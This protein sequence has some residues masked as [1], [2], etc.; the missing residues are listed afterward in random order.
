MTPRS[1][2]DGAAVRHRG[3]PR[4]EISGGTFFGP[5]ALGE[6][7]T[8][9]LPRDIPPAMSG[10][11]PRSG[12]FAGRADLLER[13]AAA[14]AP[15]PEQAGAPVAAVAGLPG[16]GK[17]EA[18]LQAAD[19][20]CREEG[21]FP[22]GVLFVDLHG[23]RHDEAGGPMPPQR[24]LRSFLAML[25]VSAEHLPDDAQDLARLYRS[26]LT[27]YAD[28]DRRVLVVIDNAASTEQVL[29]LLPGD[30]RVPAL[31]TSRHTLADLTNVTLHDLGPLTPDASLD[32]LR[33]E[34][35]RKRGPEYARV[36]EEA[37]EA[38]RVAAL[39]GHLP[40]ALHIVA[41][42]LA[43]T[44]G[45]PLS[46]LADELA[47]AT[48]TLDGLE[49]GD[50]CVRAAFGL[51][52]AALPADQARLFR[53]LPLSVYDSISAPA[54]ARLLD[55]TEAG[56]R[57]LL[58]ALARANLLDTDPGGDRW[59]MHDLVGEYADERRLEEP[60]GED[61]G[62]ALVLLANHYHQTT[63]AAASHLQP[64]AAP[65]PRFDHRASA[66]AW[67]DEERDNLVTTV[68]LFEYLGAAGPCVT[69]A[70]KLSRYLEMRHHRED[71]LRVATAAVDAA[72]A[73]GDLLLQAWASDILGTALHTANLPEAATDALR[74][75]ARL[76]GE[77]EDSASEAQALS[78]AG[79]AL[80]VLHRFDEALEAHAAARE[81]HRRSGASGEDARLLR[82]YGSTLR[83]AG[84]FDEAIAVHTAA[85]AA[86]RSAGDREAECVDLN[87]LANALADAG[88]HGEAETAYAKSV[89]FCRDMGDSAGEA[90]SLTAL[91]GL[92]HRRQRNTEALDVLRQAMDATRTAGDAHLETRVLHSMGVVLRTAGRLDEALDAQRAARDVARENAD[93]RNEAEALVQIGHLLS[94]AGRP[95]EAV[96]EA[97][98]ALE[99]FREFGGRLGEGEALNV[100]A[101]AL[102][103]LGETERCLEERRLAA[104]AF[105]DAGEPRAASTLSLLG[106]KLVEEQRWAEAVAPLER[107]VE[108]YRA[109]DDEGGVRSLLWAL[110]VALVKER[111][112]AD[113]VTLLTEAA[114]LHGERAAAGDAEA[115]EGEGEDLL[116]LG[117][118]YEGLGRPHERETAYAR[119][120]VRFRSLGDR[121]RT[122]TALACLRLARNAAGTDGWRGWL[123]W[124]RLR[125]FPGTARKDP[126]RAE[127]LRYRTVFDRR[128][129]VRALLAAAAVLTA[130]VL[131]VPDTPFAAR[132]VVVLLVLA[133]P[134]GINAVGRRRWLRRQ[135]AEAER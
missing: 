57:P 76:Y 96:A 99:L 1:V 40:L 118:A 53:L 50:R 18:V 107:A 2:D 37:G 24:A 91:A 47:D 116:W 45:R 120:V 85:L 16:V 46:H 125:L 44:P 95:G 126:A 72:E 20:A 12:A 84:S 4:H 63:G 8:L 6:N 17:T 98:L 109:R 34:L 7:V 25:G 89:S 68:F 41:A 66:L 22:G 5:V 88:R 38:A 104:A 106:L 130:H 128:D 77:L 54:A 32:L 92:L 115:A 26:A 73:D 114:S 62:E 10:L 86:S 48:R 39:C 67:L 30:P 60:E 102:D 80:Q 93:P 69:L 42:L 135:A 64:D 105:E 87:N 129:V 9:H 134:S 127:S 65:S 29:P 21:W 90:H 123:G 19:R 59:R 113:A 108:S 94:V 74:H 110:G 43:D 81:A 111:R 31:V 23:Y 52:Y 14:L 132:V 15:Q 117:H 122:K 101:G 124:L 112:H 56:T 28:R 55:A 13:L 71:W 11:P 33:A 82:R 103:D 61:G 58:R 131:T 36:D 79:S 119:A 49:R 75:A 35:R 70:A 3:Q 133:V 51:S 121:D 97:E 27:A 83:A 78:A 100:L